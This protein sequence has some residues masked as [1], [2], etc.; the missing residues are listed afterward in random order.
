MGR[1]VG[2]DRKATV[3]VITTG[4][5]QGMQNTIS[6]RT[7]RPTLKKMGYSSRRPH[8]GPLLSTKNRK[9]SA[10]LDNRRWRNVVW[11]D[12]SGFQ[13]LHSDVRVRIYC[14][15]RESMD[16]SSLVSTVQ[17]AAA[18]GGVG[19]WFKCHSLPEYRC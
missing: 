10:T 5:K 7:T 2:D 14:K 15:Q 6:E 19:S 4:Y 1:L 16:P 3:T 12:E 13:V 11:S 17:A 18:G 8:R 9:L